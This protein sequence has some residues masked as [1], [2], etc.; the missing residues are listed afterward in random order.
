VRF[1]HAEVRVDGQDLAVGNY[2]VGSLLR[3]R[4]EARKCGEYAASEC[5]VPESFA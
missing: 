4:R 1:D 5:E 2:G 3:E